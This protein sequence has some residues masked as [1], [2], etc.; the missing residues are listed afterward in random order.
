MKLFRSAL[1]LTALAAALFLPMQP[2]SH[3]QATKPAAAKPAA[4]PLVDLNTATKDQLAAL[5]G[6]GA[7]YSAKIVVGRPYANKSQL[8]TKGIVPK[9][10]YNKIQSLVIAKQGK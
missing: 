7:V 5:P 2:V 8:L 10:T 9:A 6:I 3:A 4:A 1:T